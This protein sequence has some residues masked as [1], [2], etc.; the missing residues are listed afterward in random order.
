MYEYAWFIWIEGKKVNNEMKL[1]HLPLSCDAAYFFS[2]KRR[3]LFTNTQFN[4]VQQQITRNSPWTKAK[5]KKLET[6]K[7][8][9]PIKQKEKSNLTKQKNKTKK[10]FQ[11][12]L[13]IHKGKISKKN[14]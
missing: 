7:K 12:R 2:S 11:S 10:A 13:E 14:Q 6:K 9:Q 4:K 5:T 1:T 3:K 8:K